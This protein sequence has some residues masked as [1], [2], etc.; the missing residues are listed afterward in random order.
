[1]D[2]GEVQPNILHSLKEDH[3][4]F[5]YCA[6]CCVVNALC[7]FLIRFSSSCKL[8]QEVCGISHENTAQS[9][10]GEQHVVIILL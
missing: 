9:Y 4:V 1:M 2:G 8:V 10:N 6:K 5:V 7:H 3:D